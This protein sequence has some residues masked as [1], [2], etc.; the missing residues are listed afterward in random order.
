MKIAGRFFVLF[1]QVIKC[2]AAISFGLLL[3]TMIAVSASV[4]LRYCFNYTLLWLQECIEAAILYICF[5][6]SPWVL[7]RGKHVRMDML[8]NQ[9]NAG[10]QNLLDAGTSILCASMCLI[11]L[12]YG[13]KV[14]VYNFQ[15]GLYIPEVLSLPQGILTVVVP[16]GSL[17]LF[18]EFLRR[19]GESLQ[20]WRHSEK[21]TK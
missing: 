9:L 19:T 16:A 1:D 18:I 5:L 3:T 6:V 10:G 15:K 11:V 13:T 12:W 21:Q 2:L 20:R 4:A 17:L 8:T 14:T 7:K